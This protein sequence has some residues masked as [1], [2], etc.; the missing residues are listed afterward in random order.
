MPKTIKIQHAGQ[1]LEVE[2]PEGYVGPEDLEKNYVPRTY[3]EHE[4]ARKAKGQYRKTIADL[5]TDEVKRTE[6]L[7]ELGITPAQADAI[8]AKGG[9]LADQ[10]KAAQVE[11]ER[12]SLT[13]L[14][15]TLSKAQAKITK[16]TGSKLER[17][18]VAA[19]VEAGVKKQFL[20]PLAAG[21]AAPIVTILR[22]VFGFNDEHDDFFVKQG[23][24]FAYSANPAESKVPYKSVAEY[25]TKDFTKLPHAKDYLEDVRQRGAGLN[26]GGS[27]GG[28]G[29]I[30]LTRKDAYDV[31][32]Y[33]AATAEAE[34]RGVDVEI[35]D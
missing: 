18:I 2:L 33:R 4:V 17:D 1:T 3:F 26:G 13:P 29:N 15:E 14:K 21:Q 20:T 23:D 22:D 6:F 7:T 24:E 27:Q 30:R 8:D 10:L 19:A 31:Q 16:L 25:I 5:K 32:K 11:W 9:K 12:T 34:K 35:L 28:S